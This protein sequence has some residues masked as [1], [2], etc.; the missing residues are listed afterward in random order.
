[1]FFINFDCFI[2]ISL[3]VFPKWRS[4]DRAKTPPK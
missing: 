3:I 1:L 2:D 4:P